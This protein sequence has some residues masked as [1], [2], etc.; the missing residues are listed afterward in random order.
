[1]FPRSIGINCPLLAELEASQTWI[2]NL[3]LCS[4][5]YQED[6][7]GNILTCCPRLRSIK[8]N[9]TKVTPE[10]LSI[11]LHYHPDGDLTMIFFERKKS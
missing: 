9:N 5:C 11:F 6:E 1:M 7:E 8:L 3:G 2:T 10:G 4:L